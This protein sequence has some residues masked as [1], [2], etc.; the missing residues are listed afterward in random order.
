MV[1]DGVWSG[2][3]RDCGK[4]IKSNGL[5][6]PGLRYSRT[7]FTPTALITNAVTSDHYWDWDGIITRH[8]I[9][10]EEEEGRVGGE[11]DYL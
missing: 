2:D 7:D 6:T 8:N 5:L 3:H 1:C 10:K 11:Q 9:I 4:D